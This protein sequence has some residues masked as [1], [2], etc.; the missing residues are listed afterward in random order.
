V[1]KRQMY[2]KRSTA[3]YGQMCLRK[4]G[5]HCPDYEPKEKKDNE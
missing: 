1:Y 4:V 3:L 2:Q 5:Y